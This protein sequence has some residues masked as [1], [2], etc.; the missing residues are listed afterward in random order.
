MSRVKENLDELVE[1][2]GLEDTART[3]GQHRRPSVIGWIFRMGRRGMER[4]MSPSRAARQF[5]SAIGMKQRVRE[6]GS[7]VPV[8]G[9]LYDAYHEV[10]QTC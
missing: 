2:D 5:W 1:A 8:K 7:I 4:G 3:T 10:R 9:E 6:I